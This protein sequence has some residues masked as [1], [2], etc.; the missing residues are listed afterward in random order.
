MATTNFVT[1]TVITSDWANDVDFLVYNSWVPSDYT[2]VVNSPTGVSN[3][4]PTYPI[5]NQWT[6]ESIRQN[7]AHA[8]TEIENLN[9]A[10]QQFYPGGNIETTFLN[11]SGSVVDQ[12][13]IIDTSSSTMA[14]TLAGTHI[15]INIGG[16]DTIAGGS[17]G[18]F[19]HVVA[20]TS[21]SV[22][23]GA[24][25]N[26]NGFYTRTRSLGTN[27]GNVTTANGL[28]V[29]PPSWSGSGTITNFSGVRVANPGTAAFSGSGTVS[30]FRGE[31][32]SGTGRWNVYASGTAYN[33]FAGAVLIGHSTFNNILLDVND[34]SFR[35]QQSRTPASATALGNAGEICW[36]SNYIYVC[37]ATD[38]WKRAA[39][40]TW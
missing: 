3:I 22:S 25:T 23:S 24:I 1:G 11:F 17:L 7:F 18:N 33:Y 4:D 6:T 31:V 26:W 20:D 32:A 37:V 36:D 5:E 38:T 2:L 8:K 35:I 15:G 28:L 10:L 12:G 39:L 34:N 19:H 13:R 27:T 29:D 14:S 16:T 21:I 30:A 9:D 40:S